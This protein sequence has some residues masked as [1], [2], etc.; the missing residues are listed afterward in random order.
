MQLQRAFAQL[1]RACQ[2]LPL[3]SIGKKGG[4]MEERFYR[5]EHRTKSTQ[6]IEE[7]AKNAPVWRKP[8]DLACPEIFPDHAEYQEFLVWLRETRQRGM[9]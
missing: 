6:D 7:L 1:S 8:G 4:S 2:Q 9:T 3:F 5:S